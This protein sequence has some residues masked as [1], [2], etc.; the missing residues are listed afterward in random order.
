MKSFV[1]SYSKLK[2]IKTQR[3]L[4]YCYIED[5]L[6]YTIFLV[7][8]PKDVYYY[9]K[10]IQDSNTDIVDFETNIKPTAISYNDLQDGIVDQFIKF[11]PFTGLGLIRSVTEKTDSTKVYAVSHNLGDKCTWHLKSLQITGETLIN[12]GDNLT[13]TSAYPYWIDTYRVTSDS[14]LGKRPQIYIDGV[15]QMQYN[16]QDKQTNSNLTINYENGSVLFDTPTSA[17]ITANYWYATTSEWEI[18]P[19]PGKMLVIDKVEGQFSNDMQVFND[20]ILFEVYVGPYKVGGQRYKSAQDIHNW[21]NAP[22]ISPKFGELVKDVTVFP[23]NYI[24]T[25]ILKSS[26]NMKLVIRLLENQPFTWPT[27]NKNNF[28]TATL[29]MLSEDL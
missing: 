12:S 2:T 7:D 4:S 20:I 11:K 8:N 15:P 24:S 18:S 6:I 28:A 13:F 14:N 23:W 29:Y 22:S 21:A 3:N 25:T 17:N 27:Y 16:S 1:V 10:L 26:L 19:S 9:T 5:G